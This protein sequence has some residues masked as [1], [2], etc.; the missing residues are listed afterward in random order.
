MKNLENQDSINQDQMLR[1]KQILM[2]NKHKEEQLLKKQM[3]KSQIQKF[4]KQLRDLSFDIDL[5]QW[6]RNSNSPIGN[7]YQSLTVILALSHLQAP[8]PTTRQLS[9]LPPPPS[10]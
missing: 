4:R 5:V 3:E 1:H 10:K 7:N 6:S 9:S 2:K 8:Q